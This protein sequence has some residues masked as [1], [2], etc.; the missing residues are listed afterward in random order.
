MNVHFVEKFSEG[1]RDEQLQAMRNHMT[2]TTPEKADI[3]LCASIEQMNR[4]LSIRN[5]TRKPLAVYCWDYYK[6]AHEGVRTGGNAWEWSQYAQM[7][8]E[9]DVV[10]VPSSG[11][12][13]RLKE[14]LGVDAVVVHTGIRTLQSPASDGGFILD[15]VRYY[16]EENRTWA[17]DAAH[18]LSIPIVH[19]E[20]QYSESDFKK[21]IASCSFMICAYREASTGGLTLME[22][23]SLGKVSLVSNSPYMGARDYVGDLGYYFQYDDFE[24]LKKQMHMLWTT[25]PVVGKVERDEHLAKYTFDEMARKIKEALHAHI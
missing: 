8:K 21:L 10:M 14:L 20:H 23:L 19:S 12:Q 5:T 17:E 11:Q 15:P 16:P 3:I 7:L 4:A 22:G 13:L 25:R 1:D 24:D 2:F 6:W 9:A 18:E